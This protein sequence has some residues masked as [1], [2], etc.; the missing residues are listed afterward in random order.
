MF[1]KKVIHM[2]RSNKLVSPDL[3]HDRL[4]K[5][6]MPVNSL[7]KKSLQTKSVD[8]LRKDQISSYLLLNKFNPKMSKVT[9]PKHKFEIN[10]IED[11]NTKKAILEPPNIEINLIFIVQKEEWQ[12]KKRN[13][14]FNN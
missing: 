14:H 5:I 3:A 13:S 4:E 12:N 2:H 7:Y 6:K 9:S 8:N 11:K 1:E 10:V